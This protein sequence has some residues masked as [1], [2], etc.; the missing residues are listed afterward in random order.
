MSDTEKRDY[1][2]DYRLE[3]FGKIADR[4]YYARHREERNAA[5][6][7]YWAKHREELAARALAKYHARKASAAVSSH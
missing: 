7:A 4:R 3:G 1:N 5:S 2:K 6:R